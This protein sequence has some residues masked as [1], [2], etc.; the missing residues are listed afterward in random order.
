MHDSVGGGE[1]W[2]SHTEASE[3]IMWAGEKGSLYP[4]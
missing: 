1:G 4:F 3:G 2:G